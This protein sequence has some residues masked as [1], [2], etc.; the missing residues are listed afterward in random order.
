MCIYIYHI[1]QFCLR[2][3]SS[4]HGRQMARGRS[5]YGKGIQE[6]TMSL[7]KLLGK[8]TRKMFSEKMVDGL[9]KHLS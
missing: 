3:F 9:V 8:T 1:R 7:V 6:V 4:E 5:L 2:D